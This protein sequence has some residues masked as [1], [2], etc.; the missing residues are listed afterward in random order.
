[1]IPYGHQDISQADI[2]AV[3]AVLRSDWITQGPAI[4]R[5]ERKVAEYCG[6]RYAVAVSNGTT[7]LHL[8]CCVLGVR[9]GTS[10]W[11]SPNT[12]VASANCARYCGAE[13]D[14]VDIDQ[15]TYNMSAE[16]LERKLENA[17]RGGQLP[18]VVIPVHF[19]G[20]PCDMLDI[21]RLSNKFDFKIIEDA[22]H[23]MGARFSGD[24]VGGCRYSELT[25]F[26]FHPVKI[27]T[28]GEGG[29]VTTND[30]TL[31]RKLL[32]LR[33][34]G[35]TR[36][37]SQ[38]VSNNEGPW[39]YE[40][41]ELGYNYR[42]TD[43][44]AALGASQL[45][46]LDHFVARRHELARVYDEGLKSLPLVL[47]WQDPRSYSSYHLYVVRLQLDRIRLTRREVFD[48]LRRKGI[49]V[50]VH[51]IPVHTQPYYR[52]LGFRSGSFPVAERY[53]SETLTL[54]M[55]SSLRA[56]DQAHVVLTMK[57]LLQ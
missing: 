34:H 17:Q 35:T 3:C 10:V 15:R 42:M 7:A 41:V 9:S 45:E 1:M 43:I 32:L 52:K 27:M 57:Q 16:A 28:T 54:P 25:V 44:Q 11:T 21:R 18:T 19:S 26:S 30:E 53:Y 33:S 46:R 24:P 47:P 48:A 22:S 40:Q 55:Y 31:Y 5:F 49:G 50:A 37:S 13:V 56:A 38:L 8:A 51:Y 14:F 4:E 29:V 20:Q 6:A 23:A 2:D 39:Y 36:D 12:F